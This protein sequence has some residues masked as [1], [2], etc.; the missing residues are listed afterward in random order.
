MKTRF[1]GVVSNNM[2]RAAI[3]VS[4]YRRFTWALRLSVAFA[5]MIP[6]AETPSPLPIESSEGKWVFSLLPKSFQK[7]PLV[8][9][10]VI[11][12]MTD[13]GRKF[14]P[15]TAESPVY[16]VAVSAGLHNEGHAADSD[17]SPSD[18]ALADSL[19]RAL[20]VNHFLPAGP[21]HPP[22]LLVVYVWGVHNNLDQGSDEIG[23][24]TPDVNHRN[25]LS[26]ATLVGGAKFAA[27]LKVA[28]EAQD[29][30]NEIPGPRIELLDPMRLFLARDNRT[31][32]LY[33]QASGDCY[34]LVASAYDYQTAA[35]KQGRKLLWRSK[36]TVD[37]SGV[38]MSDTLPTL[39]LNSAA[40]LGRDMPEA[41]TL[42]RPAIR[43]TEVKL[44]PLK[45]LGY[46]D[47]PDPVQ[48]YS[49][50]IKANP[51]STEK[52]KP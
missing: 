33:S 49:E 39:V 3:R 19:Q 11:T 6:A 21:D 13:E 12:E 30:V 15:P 40:Y 45:M 9:Q 8:D 14:P 18:A 1:F 20:A 29:R 5:P 27:D 26:R 34:Y 47:D 23:I 52:K 2:P 42:Y 32:R 16:Y 44:G 31:R 24:A 25:L 48:E 37:S 43:S 46:V 22:T 35:I 50:A 41:A 7:N 36:M 10:T 28:L 51:V 17:R 38:A 4:R